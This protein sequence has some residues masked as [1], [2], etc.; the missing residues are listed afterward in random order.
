MNRIADLQEDHA[1]Y[2]LGFP[3]G[4]A[5]IDW[6]IARLEAHEEGED[7]EICLLAGATTEEE[8]LPLTESI[9]RR[10]NTVALDLEVVAGKRLVSLHSSYHKGELSITDLDQIINNVY[11]RLE[12][13]SWLVMLQRNCELATDID[14]F[15]LPFEQEFDYIAKLWSTSNSVVEFQRVYSREVSNTHDFAPAHDSL[16]SPDHNGPQA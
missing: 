16:K 6:A 13:P 4:S 11:V 10:Y 1:R 3:V 15:E 9:L 2:M 5:L 12:Y 8:S 7:L 14:A